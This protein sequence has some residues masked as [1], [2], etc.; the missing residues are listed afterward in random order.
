MSGRRGVKELNSCSALE[1]G[2]ELSLQAQWTERV[3][4]FGPCLSV[5]LQTPPHPPAHGEFSSMVVVTQGDSGHPARCLETSLAV[6]TCGGGCPWSLLGGGQRCRDAQDS[7]PQPHRMIWSHVSLCPGWRTPI[8]RLNANAVTLS[9]SVTVVPTL[10]KGKLRLGSFPETGFDLG[11]GPHP[12]PPWDL[13]E[14]GQGPR[15]LLET[16][17]GPLPTPHPY[18]PPPPLL[19]TGWGLVWERIKANPP[20]YLQLDRGQE[21]IRSPAGAGG[22]GSAGRSGHV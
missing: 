15:R 17:T 13:M 9:R 12:Q 2:L 16:S 3:R 18:P 22:G 14:V 4:W 21:D 10:Q 5:Q 19:V 8:S 20:P 11:C 7:P 6:T 1:L